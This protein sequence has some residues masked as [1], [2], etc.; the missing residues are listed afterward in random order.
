MSFRSTAAAFFIALAVCA[1]AL[2]ADQRDAPANAS[3][4]PEAVERAMLLEVLADAKTP[5]PP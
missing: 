1:P 2:T 3:R 4:F 5:G